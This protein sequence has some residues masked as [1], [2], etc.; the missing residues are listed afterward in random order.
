MST[1][2]FFKV[3]SQEKK[4]TRLIDQLEALKQEERALMSLRTYL[5]SRQ[6]RLAIDKM[7]LIRNKAKRETM[8]EDGDD[9]HKA[10]ISMLDKIK[11]EAMPRGSGSID[12]EKRMQTVRSMRNLK[13]EEPRSHIDK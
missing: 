2:K 6:S 13:R 3:M 7:R 8:T 4:S 12:M 9:S 11:R 5:R 10:N 1:S